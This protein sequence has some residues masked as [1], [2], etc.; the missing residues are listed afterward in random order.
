MPLTIESPGSDYI[1]FTGDGTAVPLTEQFTT[2][3]TVPG[4]R[5]IVTPN[6]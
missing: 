4:E 5:L 1:L 6:T 3:H 2:V